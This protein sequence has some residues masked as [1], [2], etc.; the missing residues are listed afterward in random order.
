MSVQV[1]LK[2]A[3]DALTDQYPFNYITEHL[4]RIPYAVF[5]C[6]NLSAALTHEMCAWASIQVSS[7]EW[8][9]A[10]VVD[11]GNATVTLTAPLP[12]HGDADGSVPIGSSY[13][14]GPIP[15]MNVYTKGGLP[16]LPWNRSLTNK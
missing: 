10:S 12:P 15:L 13:G 14:W 4:G 16:V 6:K 8:L 3:Q 7:G 9:N 5:D 11:S 2:D 1:T